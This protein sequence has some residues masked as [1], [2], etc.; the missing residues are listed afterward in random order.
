[1]RRVG[2]L[3]VGQGAQYVGMGRALTERFPSAGGLFQQADDILGYSLSRLCFGGPAE[4]LTATEHSQPAIL[5]T[6]L[7]A[8]WSAWPPAESSSEEVVAVLFVFSCYYDFVN[9]CV[10]EKYPQKWSYSA[11]IKP[12]RM[13]NSHSFGF[14][15]L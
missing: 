4:R 3:F 8:A 14:D 12:Q 5:V 13:S 6:S 7:A 9:K 11:E 15:Y 2:C 10:I 1:M